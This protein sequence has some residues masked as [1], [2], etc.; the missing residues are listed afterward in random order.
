MDGGW[1]RWSP[2]S[3]CDKAC[4]G[5]RSIRTRSCSS[6]PPKN[7]GRKCTGEKNQVKP[8]NTKPCGTTSSTV[9]LSHSQAL[10]W[11]KVNTKIASQLILYMKNSLGNNVGRNLILSIRIW[12]CHESRLWYYWLILLFLVHSWSWLHQQRGEVV[13]EVKEAIIF[14]WKIMKT[15]FFNNMHWWIMHNKTR[16]ML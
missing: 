8:C 6:P 12:L 15:I 13:S 2:W 4:G 10:K 3:R 14:W 9:L 16:H 5:G 1:S 11:F 7:G